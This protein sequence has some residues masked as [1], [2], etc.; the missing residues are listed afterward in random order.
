MVYEIGCRFEY[1]N[2]F[3]IAG[4]SR[5]FLMFRQ[6]IVYA[7]E[8]R[9]EM[10]NMPAADSRFFFFFCMAYGLCMKPNVIESRNKYNASSK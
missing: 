4:D 10:T 1:R 9:F 7:I 5:F 6:R 2:N 8:C 3:M